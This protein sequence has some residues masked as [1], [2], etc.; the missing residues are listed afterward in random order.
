MFATPVAYLIDE[1]GII[2]NDVAVGTE[3]IQALM[4]GVAKL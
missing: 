2:T 1:H 4:S 3:Q